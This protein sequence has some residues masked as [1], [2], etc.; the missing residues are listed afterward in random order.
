M[1]SRSTTIDCTAPS[2]RPSAIDSASTP[3]VT[4][5]SAST[6]AALT[7]CSLAR[8]GGGSSSSAR[9]MPCSTAS[10]SRCTSRA[11]LRRADAQLVGELLDLVRGDLVGGAAAELAEGLA[12]A[13]EIG[14]RAVL[15]EQLLRA[16]EPGGGRAAGLAVEAPLGAA[17]EVRRR[18]SR[19]RPARAAGCWWRRVDGARDGRLGGGDVVLAQAHGA[20]DEQ[21]RSLGGR[22][23]ACLGQLDGAADERVGAVEIVGR[24]GELGEAGVDER[25]RLPVGVRL[26]VA[27]RAL[28]RA[29]GARRFAAATVD[30]AEV[31]ERVRFGDQIAARARGFELALEVR[32]GALDLAAAQERH[33]GG[34]IDAL[35]QLRLGRGAARAAEVHERLAV[36]AACR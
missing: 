5:R 30:L 4:A 35:A 2:T 11:T 28:E 24:V 29:R 1:F 18:R 9:P 14:E 17:D 8:T 22:R 10:M 23:A 7:A 21:R 12:H 34:E 13:L 3:V 27:A 15:A 32:L 20:D 26:E 36:V 19:P 31:H 6:A 33:A 16:R 25:E